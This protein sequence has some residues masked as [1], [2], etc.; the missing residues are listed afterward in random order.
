MITALGQLVD[1]LEA[2]IESVHA[3]ISELRP[4]ALDDLGLQ[5]A[6]EMLA[7]RQRVA[8][9]VEVTCHLALPDPTAHDLRLAPELETAVYRI[10]QEALTNVAKHANAKR[11]RVEVAASDGQ[12]RLEVADDGDGFDVSAPNAGF[13]LTGMQERVALGGGTID[14]ASGRAGTTVRVT[15]PGTGTGWRP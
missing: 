14:I 7:Q 15:L 12:V 11:V 9:G 1:G 10:V 8:H 2:E 3:M 13:G 6:I 4:A 5:P